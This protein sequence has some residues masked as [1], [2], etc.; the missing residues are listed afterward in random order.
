MLVDESGAQI[1][2]DPIA[3][4]LKLLRGGGIVAMKG[5][6]GFHLVCDA[7]N[8]EAVA[9][10]RQ[11]KAREEKPFAV[12]VANVASVSALVQVGIGEPGLLESAERPIV[13]MKKRLATD[14][15]LPGAAPGL[16]WLGVMLP[17]TPLQYLL[18]HEA[19]G[20]SAR[21]GWTGRSH[22]NW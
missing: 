18:F 16:A 1:D 17:Y 13:L 2:G 21:H 7:T 9:A 20:R 14:E 11:R 5:L 3:E 22:C 10:L 19:A 4:T 12:M 8:A 15:K 6:G